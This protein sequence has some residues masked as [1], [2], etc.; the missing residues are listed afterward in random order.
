MV[1]EELSCVRQSENDPAFST[2]GPNETNTDSSV[3]TV[4]YFHLLCIRSD[5]KNNKGWR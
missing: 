2:V 3:R 4:F 5:C 1:V